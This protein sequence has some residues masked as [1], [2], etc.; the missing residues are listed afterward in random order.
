MAK[1]KA[2]AGGANEQRK[3][4]KSLESDESS[5]HVADATPAELTQKEINDEKY[6]QQLLLKESSKNSIKKAMCFAYVKGKC[7]KGDACTFLHATSLK[8]DI[9]MKNPGKQK[10]LR[11]HEEN[12][13][14][15]KKK[16]DK[17]PK[18]W[19]A[20]SLPK[21]PCAAIQ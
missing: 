17:L 1:R 15:A 8:V 18:H 12:P 4:D 19:C 6:Y 3:R 10:R 21:H 2:A 16:K 9:K 13:Q 5:S 11:E 7:N 20:C 14:P